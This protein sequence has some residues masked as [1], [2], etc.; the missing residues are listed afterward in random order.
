VKKLNQNAIKYYIQSRVN[1]SQN[2]GGLMPLKPKIV[3][4]S[5]KLWNAE[6]RKYPYRGR[7][8]PNLQITWLLVQ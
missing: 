5:K 4:G 8:M 1:S 2:Q 7:A 6:A 3:L